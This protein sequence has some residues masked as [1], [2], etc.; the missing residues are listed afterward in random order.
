MQLGGAAV[1]GASAGKQLAVTGGQA[2]KGLV[3]LCVGLAAAGV[4]LLRRGRK[5]VIEAGHPLE[6]RSEE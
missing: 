5:L 3:L 1:L 4:A 2:V 6:G